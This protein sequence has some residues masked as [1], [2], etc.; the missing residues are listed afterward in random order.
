[1]FCVKLSEPEVRITLRELCGSQWND[2]PFKGEVYENSFSITENHSGIRKGFK[3]IIL[4]GY[5]YEE[6]GRTTISVSSRLSPND[7][8]VWVLFAIVSASILL[9]GISGM[10]S[11]MF[12]EGSGEPFLSFLTAVAGG[13][14]LGIV[15]S[16]SIGSYQ[17]SLEKLEKAFRA[18][19]RHA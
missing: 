6:N 13:V 11:S 2:C 10:A 12:S 17:K 3:G 18:A 16:L 9:S 7:L 15:Y 5:F 1:M 19:Q 14:F 8:V 4:D